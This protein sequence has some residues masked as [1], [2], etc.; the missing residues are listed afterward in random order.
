MNKEK[1]QEVIELRQK[2]NLELYKVL[3]QILADNPSI[4][5]GQAVMMFFKN[6]TE[7]RQTQFE[8]VVFN[9]EPVVTYARL[10]KDKTN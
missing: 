9:E 2:I 10:Q 5:F 7:E 4:R 8:N 6:N 3:G 1:Y